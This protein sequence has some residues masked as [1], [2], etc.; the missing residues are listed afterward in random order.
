MLDVGVY[1]WMDTVIN[2]WYDPGEGKCQYFCFAKGI[3][4]TLVSASALLKHIITSIYV[5]RRGN[6]SGALAKRKVT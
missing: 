1:Y 5:G 6:R 3:R 2:Y 4:G